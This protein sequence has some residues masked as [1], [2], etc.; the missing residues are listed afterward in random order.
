MSITARCAVNV[1]THS[2]LR[3]S[4]NT[5]GSVRLY[6]TISPLISMVQSIHSWRRFSLR[7]SVYCLLSALLQRAEWDTRP[8]Q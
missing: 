3:I 5:Y 4:Y 2:K 6:M 8:S 1:G 7:M